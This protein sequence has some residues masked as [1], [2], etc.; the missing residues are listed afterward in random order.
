MTV[1]DNY[2]FCE[3]SG[4]HMARPLRVQY[5]GAVYHVMARG[6]NGQSVFKDD[7]DRERF[8]ETLATEK[9]NSRA[10]KKRLK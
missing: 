5:C 3:H 8:M 2:S 10:P 1:V 6:N 7:K 4:W 9:T